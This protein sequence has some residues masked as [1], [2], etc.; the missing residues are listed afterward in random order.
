M[1]DHEKSG[2]GSQPAWERRRAWFVRIVLFLMVCTIYTLTPYV[3]DAKAA[4][5]LPTLLAGLVSMAGLYIFGAAWENRA[6]IAK[7]MFGSGDR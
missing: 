3:S 1:T 4:V 5:A 6:M 2:T 7:G